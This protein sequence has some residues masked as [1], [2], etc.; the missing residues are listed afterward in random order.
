[1]RSGNGQAGYTLIEVL[2][3]AALALVIFGGMTTLIIVLLNQQNDIASSSSAVATAEQALQ[4]FTNDTREAQNCPDATVQ[5]GNGTPV[6]IAYTTG[7]AAGFTATFY[8]PTASCTTKGALVTW[9]C[10]AG[11]G[12]SP[13][14]C[15]RQ[16]GTTTSTEING[17]TSVSITPTANGGTTL[18]SNAG[19]YD[20]T[21]NP[22]PQFPSFIQ[23]NV[24]VKPISA[25][26]STATHALQGAAN[27][28][29]LN[30]GVSLRNYL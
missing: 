13:G 3:A 12:S 25:S 7:G 17:I 15:T 2:V 6:N 21:T 26:D 11:V 23:L 28:I 27:P 30:D 24:Q 9:T 14:S 22:N 8:L 18:A 1:M 10:T 4:Q 19:L 5:G 20:A 16:V 29:T